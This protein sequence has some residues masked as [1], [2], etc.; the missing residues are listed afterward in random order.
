ML[1]ENRAIS[2]GSRSAGGAIIR[3]HACQRAPCLLAQN[4]TC[5]PPPDAVEAKQESSRADVPLWQYQ[6]SNGNENGDARK[7]SKIYDSVS[8]AQRFVFVQLQFIAL[9]VGVV[10][11]QR[12]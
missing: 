3:L 6:S 2:S 12:E 7:S 5:E 10:V 4:R 8:C 9:P 11:Q 1:S